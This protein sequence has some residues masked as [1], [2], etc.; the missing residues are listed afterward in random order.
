MNCELRDIG[1]FLSRLEGSS[2]FALPRAFVATITDTLPDLAPDQT[3]RWRIDG[4]F[5]QRAVVIEIEAA[6]DGC[7]AADLTFFSAA[8]VIAEISK[9][10]DLM[11]AT[12]EA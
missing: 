5:D 8:P 9:E 6:M 2:R 1:P 7:D 3:R 4:G 11:D 10:L 12:P